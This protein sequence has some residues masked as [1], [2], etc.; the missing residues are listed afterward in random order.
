[1]RIILVEFWRSPGFMCEAGVGSLR[2][3]SGKPAVV[4]GSDSTGSGRRQVR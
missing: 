1:M 2:N 3:L 4:E